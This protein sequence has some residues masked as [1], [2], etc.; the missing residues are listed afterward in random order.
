VNVSAAP[1]EEVE[2]EAPVS[3]IVGRIRAEF[4]EMP[5]L[6]LTA[7]QAQRLW[8]IDQATCERV[9]DSLTAS[10]FLART[11]DGAVIVRVEK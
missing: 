3:D 1:L 5:G 11:R 4:S 2:V 8:A 7:A 10:G 9:I 6:K